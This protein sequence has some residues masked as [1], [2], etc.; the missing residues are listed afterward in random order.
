MNAKGL[1]KVATVMAI[2]TAS[3]MSQG[4]TIVD[5]TFP[6]TG[7]DPNYVSV[8]NIVSNTV[9]FDSV[10]SS[11][12]LTVDQN[13]FGFLARRFTTQNLT[14]TGDYVQV[15]FDLRWT[16]LP[17]SPSGNAIR[18]SLGYVPTPY[19][20]GDAYVGW[21]SVTLGTANAA[22]VR[23]KDS[24]TTSVLYGSSSTL[25]SS[26]T[27]SPS[28]YADNTTSIDT[29]V[30]RVERQSSGFNK[31]DIT[32][33]GSTLSFTETSGTPLT[34]FNQFSFGANNADV[35]YAID[36]FKVT[37]VPEPSAGLLL[38]IG[39]LST[40]ALRRSRRSLA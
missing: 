29:V 34:Q 3:H 38:G 24:P 8:A 6:T 35:D 39:A 7:P 37:A 19:T 30:F 12:A 10:F 20:N 21:S 15:Q 2:A 33:N 17:A 13:D 16:S 28:T 4:A 36:N 11:N 5:D 9:A 40:F 18:M 22:S 26:G 23:R 1:N 14:N 32:L 25:T 27:G 31:I